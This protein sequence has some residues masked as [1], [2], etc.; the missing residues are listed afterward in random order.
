MQDDGQPNDTILDRIG[1]MARHHPNDLAYI[2]TNTEDLELTYLELRNRVVSIMTGLVDLGI[3]PRD[4]AAFLAANTIEHVLSIL[5]CGCLG[6][7]CVLLNY[8]S[9]KFAQIG[10]ILEQTKT[11][12]LFMF[13]SFNG[14]DFI[15]VLDQ[16]TPPSFSPSKLPH[17]KHVVL[18]KGGEACDSFGSFP[19]GFLVRYQD[20]VRPKPHKLQYPLVSSQDPFVI[21]FSVNRLRSWYCVSFFDSFNSFRVEQLDKPKE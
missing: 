5:A 15:S 21:V 11:K 2:F 9:F 7:E 19:D 20:L 17:L 10:D 16:L 8:V 6:V 1:Q 13:E 14:S 18:I 4:R 3:G 12:I